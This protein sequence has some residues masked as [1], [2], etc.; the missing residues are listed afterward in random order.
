[1]SDV[2]RSDRV[3]LEVEFFRSIDQ[4]TR[5][6]VKADFP[7]E[8]VENFIKVVKVFLGFQ[9]I[10]SYVVSVLHDKAKEISKLYLNWHKGVQYSLR[11]FV[12]IL[13]QLDD[14]EVI[15]MLETSFL[16]EKTSDNFFV[17]IEEKVKQG[18][19]ISNCE[20][21]FLSSLAYN[22]RVDLPTVNKF[23][24]ITQRTST[25]LV[26]QLIDNKS[27]IALRKYISELVILELSQLS[28]LVP[29]IIDKYD[30][31]KHSDYLELARIIIR[32]DVSFADKLLLSSDL[33]DLF[34]KYVLMSSTADLPLISNYCNYLHSKSQDLFDIFEKEYLGAAS[35]FDI[36]RYSDSVPFSSKRLILRRLVEI[37]NETNLVEFIKKFPEYQNLLPM[38]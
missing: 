11:K 15:E 6:L 23:L 32:H 38:L 2:I 16:K 22:S 35:S 12:A 7:E 27:H 8:E 20:K 36:V 1:M 9:D 19:D 5:L 21:M 29:V 10:R 34:E 24:E 17:L 26:E 4:A 3:K 25:F 31:K 13:V 28:V 33:R 18:K 37:K 30:D 14:P